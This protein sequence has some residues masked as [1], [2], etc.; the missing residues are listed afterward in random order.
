MRF[1]KFII[2]CFFLVLFVSCSSDKENISSILEEIESIEEIEP[3]RSLTS[4]ELEFIDEYE[5]VTFNLASDS[6]G[7]DVNEKWVTDIKLFLS[8]SISSS[9]VDQVENALINFNELFGEGTTIQLVS[10]LEESN[11]HLIFGDKD[12][13]RDV[14][15][16]MFD[17][18]GNVNFLGYALYNRDGEFNITRGRIWV[19]NTSIPL[20]AHELGHTIGLGH[21]SDSFCNG[22]AETNQSFMCSYLKDDFSSFDKAIIKT[23][24]SPKVEVGLTFSEL[25]PIIEELLLTN[26]VLVE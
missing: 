4:L 16:D 11:I 8:G 20:F 22:N 3:T 1:F 24:Y 19:R 7:A 9:Y 15:P 26:V 18:I 14:W 13:I 17:A 2:G 25:K 21:A 5:Y 10:T 6:F 12:T 23:L